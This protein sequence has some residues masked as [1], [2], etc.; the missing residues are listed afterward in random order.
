MTTFRNY[1]DSKFQSRVER[2]YCQMLTNQTIDYV[3]KMKNKYNNLNIKTNI[4]MIINALEN[5]HDESDPDNDLPQIVHAYQTS[6][7]AKKFTSSDYQI[8]DLF[9]SQEWQNLPHK[10]QAEYQNQTL[11]SFY[12]MDLD[13]FPLLGFIHDLGKILLLP[14][15]GQLPQWSVVGDT[16]PVG[17]PLCQNF[18][19]YQKMYHVNNSSINGETQ[20]YQNNCGFDKVNFSFGHDEFLANVLEKNNTRL[21]PEAIYIIRYHSFYSW[22]TPRNEIQGYTHLANELDWKMLPLLKAFQKSDLYSKTRNLPSNEEINSIFKKSFDKY[23]T[24]E[25]LLI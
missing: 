17:E 24:S 6:K 18:V 22:H 20:H 25:E 8:K 3:T 9:S 13:W 12:Q 5:I 16:F 1:T 10:Q 4:W 14:E 2:T 11:A 23:F 15:F 7:S 21:P 19:F